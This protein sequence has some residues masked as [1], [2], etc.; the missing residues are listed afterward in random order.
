MYKPQVDLFSGWDVLKKLVAL[1]SGLCFIL[2]HAV[3]SV[4]NVIAFRTINLFTLWTAG[5]MTLIKAI[6]GFIWQQPTIQY[7]IEH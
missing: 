4:N 7:V 1:S 2:L 5:S 6:T 3:K